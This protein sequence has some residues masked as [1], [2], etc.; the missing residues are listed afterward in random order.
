MQN[1]G[2]FRSMVKEESLGIDIADRTIQITFSDRD[3]ASP[4]DGS[5]IS[6][7]ASETLSQHH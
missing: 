2:A 3:Y 5:T 6:T 7:S 1:L 4:S